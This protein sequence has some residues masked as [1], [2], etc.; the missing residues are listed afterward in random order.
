MSTS[1]II[2]EA[3]GY[4][5]SALVLG[6]MLMTSVKKLRTYNTIGSVIFATYALLIHSIP[7]A[8]INIG[9]VV[10]NLVQLKKLSDTRKHYDLVETAESENTLQY[11]LDYYREDAVEYFPELKDRLPSGDTAFLVCCQAVPA[12]ILIGTRGENG[13]MEV[14]LD[15]AT[16]VYR[17]C[18]VGR[19]L[20]GALP[21][22][23]VTRLHYRGGSE[24]H[25]K[26]LK[27]MGFGETENGVYVKEL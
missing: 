11:I 22:Y 12:G 23:G 14:A 10:I 7:T 8:I 5:G 17:D 2:I 3:I 19:F 27:K 18:S 1:R 9:L 15:Y 26:Y 13:D 20:Y 25:R 16:P 21:D 24:K 4:I 6:S